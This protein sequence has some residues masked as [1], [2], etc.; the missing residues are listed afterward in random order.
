[1]TILN[2]PATLNVEGLKQG[3]ESVENVSK[4]WPNR[5]GTTPPPFSQFFF[6][7]FPFLK[8]DKTSINVLALSAM[9][10]IPGRGK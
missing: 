10:I 9:A 5:V 2:V 1:M 8:Q 6:F 7:S 4:S 3:K